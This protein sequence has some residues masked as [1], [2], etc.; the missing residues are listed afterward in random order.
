M[1]DRRT[2]ASHA[3]VGTDAVLAPARPAVLVLESRL[4]RDLQLTPTATL[5][6]KAPLPDF[7]DPSPKEQRSHKYMETYLDKLRFS[8][9]HIATPEPKSGERPARLPSWPTLHVRRLT[10]KNQRAFVLLAAS[11]ANRASDTL[12]GP[13]R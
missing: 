2:T 5:L 9:Y 4:D 7:A 8:V 6:Q 12:F 13:V 1:L 11:H 3:R 10:V